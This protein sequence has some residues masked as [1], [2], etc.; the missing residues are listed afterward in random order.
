LA[1]I[2]RSTHS[3]SP[4]VLHH[5][6]AP[7]ISNSFGRTEQRRAWARFSITVTEP[8]RGDER[9]CFGLMPFLCQIVLMRG[10]SCRRFG[11]WLT[12]QGSAFI[13]APGQSSHKSNRDDS[14][15]DI[16]RAQLRDLSRTAGPTTS[17]KSSS[18]QT[19]RISSTL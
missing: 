7:S 9:C 5:Q 1:S 15:T 2:I 11:R 8:G 17:G 13:N 19:G 4:V 12:C 6:P 16:N 14:R 10:M 3:C 18:S